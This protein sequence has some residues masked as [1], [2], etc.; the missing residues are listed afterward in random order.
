MTRPVLRTLPGAG[1]QAGQDV[2]YTS[3]PPPPRTAAANGALCH[4]PK[5]SPP[6]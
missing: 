5:L 3:S 2:M 4:E 1:R 6:P